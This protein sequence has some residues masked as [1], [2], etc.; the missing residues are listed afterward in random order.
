[1]QCL[2]LPMR[3]M[4]HLTLQNEDPNI[5]CRKTGTAQVKRI[6]EAERELQKLEQ[7]PY[8]E[9]D[10]LGILHLVPIKPSVL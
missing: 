4:E 2:N 10:V 6:T 5:N 9:R 3:C 7:I 8:K 1:M